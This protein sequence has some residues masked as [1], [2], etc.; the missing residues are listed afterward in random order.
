LN[1]ADF[2][3]IYH[4][5]ALFEKPICIEWLFLLC[6]VNDRNISFSGTTVTC[7]LLSFGIQFTSCWHKISK[8][9]IKG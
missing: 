5:H 8:E 9:A 6:A 3:I 2:N 1:K 7:Y 4:A